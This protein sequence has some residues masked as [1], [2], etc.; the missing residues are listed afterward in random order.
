MLKIQASH[1]GEG[2]FKEPLPNC[3]QS[4]AAGSL[5]LTFTNVTGLNFSIL[6]NTNLTLPTTSWTFGRHPDRKSRR[7]LP[8]H[9]SGHEQNA[10]LSRAVELNWPLPQ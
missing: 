10:F 8:I 6:A 7:S 3:T 5:E 1:V 4:G 2:Q 9:R